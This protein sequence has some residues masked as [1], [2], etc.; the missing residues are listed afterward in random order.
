M[1]TA[2][3]CDFRE[4]LTCPACG[5]KARRRPHIRVC[6]PPPNT[7]RPVDVGALVERG[8]TAIGVTPQLVE[9]LTGTTGK[10]GGCGCGRRKKWLTE[11]GNEAQVAARKALVKV[12]QFYLGD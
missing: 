7:W 5:Y 1:T 6:R 2:K 10:P 8:L 11:K 3:Y 9:K 4:S 12:R